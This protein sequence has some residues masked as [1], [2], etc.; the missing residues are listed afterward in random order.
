MKYFSF[1]FLTA[2][3]LLLSI[4]W[5]A[6]QEIVRWASIGHEPI[7]KPV[8]LLTD[9]QLR[10]GGKDVGRIEKGTVIRI[11]GRAKDSPMEYLSVSMGWENRG[12]DAQK[13][14]RT[15]SNEES[16]LVEMV[17]PKQ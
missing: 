8:V 10:Q 17:I 6:R 11:D 14:Y 9:V 3:V 13:V 1:G 16:A 7:Q 2:A 5:F 4:L 15:L 12:A